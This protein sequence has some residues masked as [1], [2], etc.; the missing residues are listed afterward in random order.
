MLNPNTLLTMNT[1]YISLIACIISLIF[2][3]KSSMSQV[4]SPLANTNY[5]IIHSSGSV[6][7]ENASDG[8]GAIQAVT[9]NNNQMMQFIAD[10]TGYYSIKM[11]GQTKYL[12]LSGSWNTSFV[13]SASTDEAKFAIEKVSS[14]FVIIKCKA[15]GKCLGTDNVTAGSS[16]FADKTGTDSKHYWFISTQYTTCL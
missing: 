1:K 14:V 13:T 4:V 10:G 8:H 16:L 3:C 2:C 7:G 11:V 9:G 6:I 15:N 5:Y 12:S